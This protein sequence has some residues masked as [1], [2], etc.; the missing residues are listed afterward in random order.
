MIQIVRHLVGDMK[1]QYLVI[2][3][4]V[5][6]S[7]LTWAQD[8][9]S[10]NEFLYEFLQGTY[11]L[12]GRAPDSNRTYTGKVV[13]RKSGD[14]FEVTSRIEG[15]EIKG[16]GKI[17]TA[18]ADKIKVLRVRFVEENKSYEATYLIGSDLDNYGRLTGYLYLK[19]G[20]TK[21]P[22]LEALFIDHQALEQN[23][24]PNKPINPIQ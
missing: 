13:L 10:E 1:I 6:L 9:G 22:G 19:E 7:C 24:V 4:V 17:E 12:I 15:K 14:Y 18:T 16:T 21:V 5:C 23:L 20:G 11:E 2:V 8:V 3:A